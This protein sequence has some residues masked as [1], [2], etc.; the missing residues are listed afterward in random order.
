MSARQESGRPIL[1]KVMEICPRVVLAVSL[2]SSSGCGSG[3]NPTPTSPTPTPGI[4]QVECLPTGF[5]Y[6]CPDASIV[7]DPPLPNGELQITLTE[8]RGRRTVTSEVGMPDGMPY[9]DGFA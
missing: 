5:G 2:A 7:Q 4:Y 9:Q 8:P 3:E 1:K 6:L